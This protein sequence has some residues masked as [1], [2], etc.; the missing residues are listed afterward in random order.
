L[1]ESKIENLRAE[2]EKTSS[3]EKRSELEVL[4]E[5]QWENLA[6]VN[7]KIFDIRSADE[8][9]G[10]DLERLIDNNSKLAEIAERFDNCLEEANSYTQAVA[11]ATSKINLP[12]IVGAALGAGGVVMLGAGAAMAAGAAVVGAAGLGGLVG[13]LRWPF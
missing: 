11:A 13:L 9:L 12:G 8:R 2:I 4:L 7:G 10:E 6:L 3:P 1:I 5:K